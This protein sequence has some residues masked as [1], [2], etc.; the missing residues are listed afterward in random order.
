MLVRLSDSRERDETDPAFMAHRGPIVAWAKAVR[1][2]MA[3][4]AVMDRMVAKARWR[5]SRAKRI[6]ASVYGPAAALVATAARLGWT[7]LN[8]TAIECDDGSS[9]DLGCDPPA[10]VGERVHDAVRRWQCRRIARVILGAGIGCRITLGPLRKLLHGRDKPRNFFRQHRGALR[11]VLCGGQW[12]QARLFTAALADDSSCQLCGVHCTPVS[13][14][15]RGTLLHRLQCPHLHLPTNPAHEHDG[16]AGAADEDDG[17]DGSGDVLDGSGG[18]RGRQAVSKSTMRDAGSIL[19]EAR[20]K[21]NNASDEERGAVEALRTRG[22]MR[23]SLEDV[24]SRPEGT[25]HWVVKPHRDMPKCTV[26][27]DASAIDP[28]SSTRG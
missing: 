26:Y 4:R 24:G 15:P 19:A 6:W 18:L 8:S 9:L 17:H 2:K 1:A 22:W 3:P 13:E 11:S 12:P 16:R 25:F 21:V 7:V 5:L 28:P 14:A 27:T 20:I 23:S 10:V